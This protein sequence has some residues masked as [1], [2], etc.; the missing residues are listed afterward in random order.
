MSLVQTQ[1]H[2][3]ITLRISA[4]QRRQHIGGEERRPSQRQCAGET[5]F[6]VVQILLQVGLDLQYLF[7]GA[8]VGPPQLRYPNGGGAAIENGRSDARFRLSHHLAQRRLGNI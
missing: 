1:L 2:A 4:D 5:F 7:G 3:G 8:D 6:R